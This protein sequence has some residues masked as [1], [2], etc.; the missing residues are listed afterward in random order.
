MIRQ[1]LVAT[2]LG[3]SVFSFV[4]LSAR[5]EMV[6]RLTIS[7]AQAVTLALPAASATRFSGQ[8]LPD[9][10]RLYSLPHNKWYLRDLTV[11]K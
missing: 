2:S 3:V 1:L 5:S 4:V 7:D 11:E 6:D 9:F 10:G 8:A